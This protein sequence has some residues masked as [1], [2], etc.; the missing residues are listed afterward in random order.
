MIKK[1][2][3]MLISLNVCLFAE[4]GSNY[5]AFGIGDIESV[6]GAAY[7]GLGG[8]SVAVPSQYHINMTN[9]AMWSHLS[10]TRIQLGYKFQQSYVTSSS[11]N[12]F[13]NNGSIDGINALFMIDTSRG[14]SLGFG[15]NNY[16]NV[17]YSIASGF[18]KIIDN[19]PVSGKLENVGTGGMKKIYIGASY[20]PFSFLSFGINHNVYL[21][22]IQRDATTL[23]N[24]SYAHD[25]FTGRKYAFSGSNQRLGLNLH[26]GDLML[27][28]F[29]ETSAKIENRSSLIYISYY[30]LI[31]SNS[32]IVDTSFNNT[33]YFEI[34]STIGFGASYL[35]DKF[36]IAADFTSQDFSN[37]NFN[38]R[39]NNKF[40]A[41]NTF[42]FGIE[43][44]G[45]TSA[46]ADVLD[47]WTYRFGLGYKD[48][49]L[50]I[51]NKPINEMYLSLG[52]S[53]PFGKTSIFD[54]AIVFGSRGQVS[55]PLVQEYFTR[56]YFNVSIGEQWFVP[57][58]RE[59]GD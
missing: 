27:G 23:S 14:I 38:K 17:S 6:Q 28:G 43:R 29:Y 36:R 10:L 8:A 54:Y 57:F 32:T 39:D 22:T 4:G 15:L 45:N 7:M 50:N 44:L 47:K 41:L 19:L 18:S 1:I 52:L 9:P 49:Y 58:K 42:S 33:N 48:L 51:D 40:Q 55:S 3:I 37:F 5:S 24:E 2:L 31:S 11:N 56:M 12:I 20:K 46:G 16:T 21:G 35:I 59:F 30:N 34:P 53:A 25:S 26:F 13:Q